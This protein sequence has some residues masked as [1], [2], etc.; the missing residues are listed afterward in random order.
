MIR[1][2]ES[3]EMPGPISTALS[4]PFWAA[5]RRNELAL[6]R[7]EACAQWFFYPR[8]Y[9]P[10]CWSERVS[11]HRASGRGVVKSF[12]VVHR[13]GHFAW[14]PAVP[15]VIALIELAEGPT[16]LSQLTGAGAEAAKV[17]QRVALR[18]V[19]VGKFILPFFELEQSRVPGRFV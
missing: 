14:S 6:Q 12:S 10:H 15:Y 11:W 8:A 3:L 17:G 7:C 4:E 2:Y 16:M 19:S 13:P 1:S 9:C 5:A 18:C